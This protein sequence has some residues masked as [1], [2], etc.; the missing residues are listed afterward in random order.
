MTV[1][2]RQLFYPGPKTRQ[3]DSN[4]PWPIHS[5]DLFNKYYIPRE[6]LE[7]HFEIKTGSKWVMR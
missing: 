4:R 3:G 2:D 5:G 7:C 1:I 6:V